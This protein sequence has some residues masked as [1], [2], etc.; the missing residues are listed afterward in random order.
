MILGLIQPR[1]ESQVIRKHFQRAI[2]PGGQ[3]VEQL[4][5]Y[6]KQA[7]DVITKLNMAQDLCESY[8]STEIITVPP[9]QQY[10]PS[11]WTFP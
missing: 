4:D 8:S 9:M 7:N 5:K 2:K 6:L 1:M 10:A 3:G 11:V